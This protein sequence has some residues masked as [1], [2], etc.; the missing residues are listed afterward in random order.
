MVSDGATRTK[1]HAACASGNA[2]H[3]RSASAKLSKWR[4]HHWGW[5]QTTAAGPSTRGWSERPV[6]SS[7][8]E[9][10]SS[11]AAAP[12]PNRCVHGGGASAPSS[13]E[14]KMQNELQFFRSTSYDFPSQ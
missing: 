9:T 11:K 4:A 8:R 6:V 12:S 10:L 3:N 7:S 13:P 5:S 14:N 1:K 2:A